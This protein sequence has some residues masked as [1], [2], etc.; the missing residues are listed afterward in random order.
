MIKVKSIEMFNT[1][2][3][4][5]FIIEGKKGICVGENVEIDGNVYEVKR[6]QMLTVPNREDCVGILV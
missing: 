5:I 4:K 2:Q 6:I 1:S 3:G